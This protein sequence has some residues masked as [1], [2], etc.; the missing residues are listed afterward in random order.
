MSFDRRIT[1]FRADLADERLRGQV[2]ANRFTTG[3]DKR[4]IASSSAVDRHSSREAPVDTQAIFREAVTVYDENEGWAWV[5]LHEDG[6][7]GYLPAEAL[8]D[9][10]AE[11]THK[12]RAIRTFVYPGPNLKLPYQDYL[13]LNAKV[14][15]TETQIGRAHV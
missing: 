7:V 15:I 13:T 4:V 6:Y 5:Q 9:A 3:T 8:G 14:A 2:E 1:P 12:V 10:G 11:P